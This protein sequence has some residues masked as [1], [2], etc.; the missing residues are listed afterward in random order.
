LLCH[1]SSIRD[2]AVDKRGHI[3]VTTGADRS[4]RIWDIRNYK[5]LQNFKLRSIPSKLDMSQRNLLAVSSGDVVE[6]YK[7]FADQIE[8]PYMR[9]RLESRS[10]II[11]SVQFCPYEDVLG[12]GH[13]GGF[14]SLLIP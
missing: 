2:I 13:Q 3:M 5:C 11:S 10:S 6:V 7:L 14:T 12:V 8:K 9:H 4:I 1:P